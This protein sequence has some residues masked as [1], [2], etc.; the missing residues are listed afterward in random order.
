MVH[1]QTR[2]RFNPALELVRQAGVL[3]TGRLLGLGL[4]LCGGEFPLDKFFFLWAA[5]KL[6]H[7]GELAIG[8]RLQPPQLRHLGAGIGQLLEAAQAVQCGGRCSGG[9]GCPLLGP[10]QRLRL[11]REAFSPLAQLEVDLE[12]LAV[13][14]ELSG[15]LI[16][17]VVRRV[18]LQAIA[19][20]GR[21]INDSDLLRAIRQELEKEGKGV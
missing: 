18:S 17:N 16:L 6:G 2:E 4:K 11:W 20:G 9:G 10:E 8:Q 12:A 1:R 19:A 5:R 13:R 21:P 14:H 7:R 15:G 3:D